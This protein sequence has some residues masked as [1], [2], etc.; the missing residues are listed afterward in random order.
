MM[1]KLTNQAM[2]KDAMNNFSISSGASDEYC[3]GI[4]VGAVSSLIAAGNKF[5][6]VLELCAICMPED[7][8][9][10]TEQCVPKT[11]LVDTYRYFITSHRLR[12]E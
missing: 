11:W 12:S 1:P 2:L 6:D 9:R 4:L 5:Y 3:R 8:R 7:T 10:L